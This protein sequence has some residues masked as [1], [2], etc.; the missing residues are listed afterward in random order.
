[1]EAGRHHGRRHR[2]PVQVHPEGRQRKRDLGVRRQPD[3][4]RPGERQG[5]TERHLAE[6]TAGALT[7][8]PIHPSVAG[9]GTLWSSTDLDHRG[10]PHP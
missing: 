6:L 5:R 2:L 1:M 7:A 8:P 9:P 10:D 3:G 4:H